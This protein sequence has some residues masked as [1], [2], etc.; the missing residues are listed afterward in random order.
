MYKA[1]Q[2]I[3]NVTH[4]IEIKD[5]NGEKKVCTFSLAINT[6]SKDR[7]TTEFFDFEAW[8]GTADLIA[9]YVH[10]GDKLFVS[11]TPKCQSWEDNEGNKHKRVV[12]AVDSVEF[13]S[14]KKD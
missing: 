10:K 13:C 3:G 6:K 11:C 2:F 4:D 1:A 14:Q 8:N 9:K 12:F 5:L 7:E